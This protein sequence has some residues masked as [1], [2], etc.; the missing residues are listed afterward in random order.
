LI[1]QAFKGFRIVV[2]DEIAEVLGNKG[3][4][5]LTGFQEA[6]LAKNR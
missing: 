4:Q 3:F 2:D 1:A 5:F 6:F